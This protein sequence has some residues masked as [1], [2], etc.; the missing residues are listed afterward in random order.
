MRE[1][2][3]PGFVPERLTLAREA[4][5]LT[6]TALADVLDLSRESISRYERGDATPGPEIFSRI[7][8]RLRIPRTYLVTPVSQAV[9]SPTFFR[10]M[11]NTGKAARRRAHVLH[12]WVHD[13]AT[14][15]VDKVEVPQV[16]VPN[17]TEDA[18]ASSLS[19]EDVEEAATQL[20]RQWGM[21]D[22]PISDLI[23]LLENHGVIVASAPLE[24]A[25]L[26][27]LSGWFN[28]RPVMLLNSDKA[29]AARARLDAAHELG[30]L[31]LHRSVTETEI[32]TGQ[33]F[34]LIET[35]AFRFGAAF[36]FPARSFVLEARPITL[37]HLLQLKKRWSVSV[38]MMIHRAR[39]L[40]LLDDG[41]AQ[42]MWKKYT[43]HGWRGRE[44]LDDLLP[45]ERPRML[46]RAINLLIDA[47]AVSRSEIPSRA[48]LTPSDV[49]RLAGLPDG[50]LSGAPSP[51]VPIEPR[52]RSLTPPGEGADGKILTFRRR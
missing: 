51:V 48:N 44:P 33:Q 10:S 3:T 43:Y 42:S 50:H 13:I 46:A 15:L 19:F 9:R 17:L 8:D 35:Q 6:C 24:L 28:E 52:L 5:G 29:T 20:R 4:R 27:G 2:G 26:D 1:R 37:D 49:E 38:A 39:D 22:G 25:G 7:C 40:G 14:S 47:G 23:L 12:A 30:H 18:R 36:L 45:I 41:T 32:N 21:G 11:S 31:V 16:S 34:K